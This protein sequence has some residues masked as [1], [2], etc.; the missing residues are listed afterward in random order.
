MEKDILDN[1]K[2]FH[3]LKTHFNKLKSNCHHN[4]HIQNS[5]NK[6]GEDIFNFE[7]LNFCPLEELDKM[8]RFYI[9]YY[10]FG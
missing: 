4:I 9:N 5:F 6:Y 1:L 10:M 3:R 7:V 2:M 8:E